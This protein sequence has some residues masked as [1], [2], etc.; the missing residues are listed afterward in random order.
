M[1]LYTLLFVAVAAALVTAQSP[2]RKLD[3]EFR[4]EH[5]GDVVVAHVRADTGEETRL[6][7]LVP[8]QV[9]YVTSYYHHKFKA[10]DA[11]TDEVLGEFEV[12]PDPDSDIAFGNGA[13]RNFYIRTARRTP[14]LLH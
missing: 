2:D 12:S 7:T 5:D 4:N 13:S 6:V 3:V 14:E 8:R 10:Y 9:Q 11:A 1:A